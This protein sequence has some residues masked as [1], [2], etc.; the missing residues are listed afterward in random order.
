M[1]EQRTQQPTKRKLE[2]ARQE[3]KVI[4][5]QLVTQSIGTAA[6]I[7]FLFEIIRKDLVANKIVLEYLLTAGYSSPEL[8]AKIA[9][10]YMVRLVV[11]FLLVTAGTSVLTEIIQVGLRFEF[12]LLRP[13][14]SRLQPSNLFK[15][16]QQ[17]PQ[18]LLQ[19]LLRSLVVISVLFWLFKDSL[20]YL[21]T[22]MLASPQQQLQFFSWNLSRFGLT[23]ITIM[24][25]AA[26]CDYLV[27]RR[28]FNREMM[29]SLTEVRNEHKDHEGDPLYRSMRRSMHES[30]LMQDLVNRV[31][32]AKVVVVDSA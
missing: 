29:M 3:G 23:A 6:G 8:T 14:L 10:S 26:A 1:S 18:Q 32:K 30:I 7:L 21:P 28:R 25:V 4:K 19:L 22:L 16:L 12:S 27:Q 15:K 9:L 13:K 20:R 11:L 17:S 31:R 5:S 24:F 2:K